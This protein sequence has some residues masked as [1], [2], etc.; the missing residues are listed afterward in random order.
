[1]DGWLMEGWMEGWMDGWMDDGGMD[2]GMDGWMMEGWMD[3]W[4]EQRW[5]RVQLL[6]L[7]SSQKQVLSSDVQTVH[8]DSEPTR[9]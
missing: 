4:M 9:L 6:P 7:R 1:M 2:G 5:S 8:R 3:G